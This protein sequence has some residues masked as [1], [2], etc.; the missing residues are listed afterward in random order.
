MVAFGNSDPLKVTD[1]IVEDIRSG[2][3]E[4]SAWPH[5]KSGD[6]VRIGP[7]GLDVDHVVPTAFW[8][9]FVSMGGRERAIVL[10][11]LL[12]REH[13]V[14]IAADRLTLD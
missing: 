12:G 2:C 7:L 13:K 1:Q 3:R 6:R 4:A 9:Q 8:G 10:F 11:S 5:V 14:E